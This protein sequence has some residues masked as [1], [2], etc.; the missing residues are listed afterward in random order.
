VTWIK[1]R[2]KRLLHLWSEVLLKQSGLAVSYAIR[3]G[4][5]VGLCYTPGPTRGNVWEL[6]FRFRAK[7]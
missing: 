3:P 1:K 5:G 7:V 4:N 2:N 6:W